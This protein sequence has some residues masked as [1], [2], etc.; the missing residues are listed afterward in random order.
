M[1]NCHTQDSMF[2]SL[3]SEFE[4]DYDDANRLIEMGEIEYAWD[5]NGNASTGSARRLLDD[6]CKQK[7]ALQRVMFCVCPHGIRIAP[8]CGDD[9][10]KQKH[11]L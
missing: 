2:G 10:R 3:P 11:A 9:G 1:V 6:G 4:Y 8:P 7:H 5:D